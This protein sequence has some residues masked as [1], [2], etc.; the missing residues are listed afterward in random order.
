MYQNI[1]KQ[2]L[3]SYNFWKK[4][5]FPEYKRRDNEEKGYVYNKKIQGKFVNVNNSMAVT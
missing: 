1:S 2:I 4:N 5:G 3:W